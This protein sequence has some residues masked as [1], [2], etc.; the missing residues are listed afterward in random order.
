MNC[1]AAHTSMQKSGW[2]RIFL[3]VERSLTSSGRRFWDWPAWEGDRCPFI[4]KMAHNRSLSSS[5]QSIRSLRTED[6]RA[7]GRI[8]SFTLR[9]IKESPPY[10]HDG[11]LFDA[12]RYRRI[13]Q[14]CSR[15]QADGAGEAGFGRIHATTMKLS[16][17]SSRS[18]VCRLPRQSGISSGQLRAPRAL[19]AL[20]SAVATQ[21]VPSLLAL[22]L[23]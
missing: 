14:P 16:P 4:S 18:A 8:N 20:D 19:P 23:G 7:V 12:R 11:R 15:A 3:G 5:V 21:R 17:V 1:D 2:A 9:G 6:G 10:L 13:L 22:P